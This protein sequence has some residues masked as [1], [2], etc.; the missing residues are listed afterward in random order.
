M[1]KIETALDRLAKLAARRVSDRAFRVDRD[2]VL[3][4]LAEAG[5]LAQRLRDAE[6]RLRVREVQP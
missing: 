6:G 3:N 1:E 4:A 2:L 5:Y